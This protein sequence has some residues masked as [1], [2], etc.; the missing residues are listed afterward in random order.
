MLALDD[1]AMCR[2]LIAATAMETERLDA[3]L[4]DLADRLELAVR[5]EAVRD[6]RN[7]HAALRKTRA[8]RRQARYR[9]RAK[10]R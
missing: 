10:S 8:A 3:W 4:A 7:H 9:D 5:A 1:P 2:L 6:E